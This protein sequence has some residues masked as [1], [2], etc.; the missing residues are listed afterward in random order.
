MTYNARYALPP[1]H[2][3]GEDMI[4][5]WEELLGERVGAVLL[6]SDSDETAFSSGTVVRDGADYVLKC[7]DCV[8]PLLAD[9]KVRLRRLEKPAE[10][11]FDGVAYI[12]FLLVTP[13]PPGADPNTLRHTGGKCPERGAAG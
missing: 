1:L 10:D 8:F 13:I 12:V 7:D 6:R 3:A 9:I 4:E 5:S 11:K 2:T